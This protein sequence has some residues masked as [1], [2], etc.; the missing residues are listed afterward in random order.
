MPVELDVENVNN[1][2]APGM[3][4]E[5]FW[6]IRRDAP[7]LFVPSSA[8]VQTTETTYVDRVRG[9]AIEQVAVQRGTALKD[10]VEV[11]GPL[12]AGDL[13]LS[14][15]SEE[16][17]DGTKVMTKPYIPDGGTGT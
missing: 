7:S 4:A 10:R 3:F 2:L 17:K 8:I 11:F 13:V 1:K 6:P 15:G 14:R 16:L 12:Q 5:V 9:G